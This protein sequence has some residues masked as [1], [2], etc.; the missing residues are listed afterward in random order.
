M[1]TTRSRSYVCAQTETVDIIASLSFVSLVATLLPFLRAIS[2]QIT[3][4]ID[5]S[6]LPDADRLT[7]PT[8][9]FLFF[10]VSRSTVVAPPT[11]V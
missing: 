10:F 3:D 8:R 9:L 5:I 7:H 4:L 11:F 1:C 6:L 2:P